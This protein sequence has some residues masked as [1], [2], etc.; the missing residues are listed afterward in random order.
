MVHPMTALPYRLLDHTADLGFEIYGRDLPELFV[1]ACFTLFD[2]ITDLARVSGDSTA[3]ITV[4]GVDRPELMINWLRE[5]LS[6][7]TVG[8]RLIKSARIVD[9]SETQLTAEITSAPYTPDRHILKTDIKA[10][11]YHKAAVDR[12]ENGWTARVIVDV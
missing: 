12:T 6:L 8:N 5:L 10:V 7:W 11:T 2:T 4:T 1:N 3:T 9:L